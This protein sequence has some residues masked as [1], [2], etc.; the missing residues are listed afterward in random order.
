MKSLIPKDAKSTSVTWRKR[1]SL[2]ES[3]PV[4]IDNSKFNLQCLLFARYIRI[5]NVS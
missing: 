1:V 3:V 5:I 4:S 2:C